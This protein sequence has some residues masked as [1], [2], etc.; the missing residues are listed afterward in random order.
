[1]KQQLRNI[2]GVNAGHRASEFT[3]SS[4]VKKLTGLLSTPLILPSMLIHVNF[5]CTHGG[6]RFV[7]DLAQRTVFR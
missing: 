4:G 6:I 1:M 7:D 5:N 3:L 2:P